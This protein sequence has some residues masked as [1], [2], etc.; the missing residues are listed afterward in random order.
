MRPGRL[1]DLRRDVLKP[2][3][4]EPL[5]R[6]AEEQLRR[7][8]GIKPDAPLNEGPLDVER[9]ELNENWYLTVGGIGFS[10]EPYEVA[11]FAVG[12]VSYTLPWEVLKPWLLEGAL[13]Q[14]P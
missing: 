4:E 12:F 11:S 5:A 1:L 14:R 3:Y 8:L 7:Y 13:G 9:I 6:A 2:G 10:H